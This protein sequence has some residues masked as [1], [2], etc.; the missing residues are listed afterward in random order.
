MEK[1]PECMLKDSTTGTVTISRGGASRGANVIALKTST[2][3]HYVLLSRTVRACESVVGASPSIRLVTTMLK[4]SIGVSC[5]CKLH[6]WSSV[7]VTT[8]ASSA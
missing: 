6:L 5:D 2:G 4:S 3:M 7:I 1:M 8:R